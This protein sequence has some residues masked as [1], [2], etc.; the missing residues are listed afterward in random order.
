[1]PQRFTLVH[2]EAKDNQNL[3]QGVIT[4]SGIFIS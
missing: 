2:R 1:M 4:L 3:N